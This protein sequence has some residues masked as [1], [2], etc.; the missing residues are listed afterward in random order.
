VAPWSLI[1]RVDR[2]HH[3][4]SRGVDLPDTQRAQ[5]G[6]DTSVEDRAVG[7]ERAGPLGFSN[8]GLLDLV[9]PDAAACPERGPA[10]GMLSRASAPPV[11]T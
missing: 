7:V 3:L 5:W 9:Q 1:F 6:L 8:D 4:D 10:S 2:R 11:A